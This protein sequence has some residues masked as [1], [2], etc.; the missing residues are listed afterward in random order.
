MSRV[1]RI[2]EA[3]LNV[4]RERRDYLKD[5]LESGV[6]KHVDYDRAEI[7]ALEWAIKIIER[8]LKIANDRIS[9]SNAS[10]RDGSVTRNYREEFV[11]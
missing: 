10:F 4:L 7:A 5:R 1:T 11:Q 2:N 3:R 6:T 9:R 8:Y